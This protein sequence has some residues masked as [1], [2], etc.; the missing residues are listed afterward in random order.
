[1]K[2]TRDQIIKKLI[3][4]RLD[5]IDSYTSFEQ[6]CGDMIRNGIKGLADYTDEELVDQYMLTL[7]PEE[8]VE[9]VK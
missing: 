9:L 8:D 5:S 6:V 2:L 1:M 3:E 4:E 7:H